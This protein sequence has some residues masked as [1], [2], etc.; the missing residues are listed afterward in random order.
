M[1]FDIVVPRTPA[2][3]DA[4]AAGQPVVLRDPADPASQA[5]VNL[6]TLLA[7]RFR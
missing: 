7:E 5:Y 1:V 2:T 4:F 3:A 6:A